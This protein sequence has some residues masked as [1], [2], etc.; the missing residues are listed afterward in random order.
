M[1][2]ASKAAKRRAN[3]PRYNQWIRGSVIDVGC[4][5]DPINQ[6]LYPNISDV[7]AYDLILGHK[8]AC[9][10]P[11]IGDQKFDCVHSS[12]CLEHLE[13]PTAALTRWMDVLKPGGHLVVTIP[14]E[15]AY[16]KGVFPSR[17]NADHKNTFTIFK[18][19]SWSP[20]SRNVLFL[21][22]TLPKSKIRIIQLLDYGVDYAA[23][24]IDQT[25]SEDGPECAIEFVVQ[26]VTE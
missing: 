20:R 9:Y 2:E 13:T 11:E 16:E 23:K 12:H 7:F 19:E 14:D 22:M 6:S 1:K 4:G 3:D 8:D 21:L 24:D 17:W 26:K 15:D 10:L 18:T 25:F 5:D